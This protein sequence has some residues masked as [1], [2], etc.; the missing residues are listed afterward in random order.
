VRGPEHAEE[1]E[2]PTGEPAPCN[3]F[4]VA[5]RAPTEQVG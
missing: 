3:A 4:A 2:E 5:N 1:L